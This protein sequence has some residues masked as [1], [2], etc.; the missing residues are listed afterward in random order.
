MGRI[1]LQFST[2]ADS[3]QSTVIRKLCHS[4]F[5]HCDCVLP[6]GSLLGASGSPDCPVIE[7]NPNGVA[8]RPPDYQSFGIR[9]N[10]TLYVHDTV[11]ERF[12]ADLRSQVGK[13]FDDGALYDFFGE[14]ESPR[15]WRKPDMWFCTELFVLDMERSG[16]FPYELLI[17]KN[18]V[19]PADTLLLLN[20][21]IDTENFWLPIPGLKLGPHER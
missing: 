21:Y 4:P 10:A 16:V 19:S 6:D 1:T 20:P 14:F 11:E 15:D 18:R 12:I 7:G 13:P 17:P 5:S 2:Q 8:I 3:W 9:R